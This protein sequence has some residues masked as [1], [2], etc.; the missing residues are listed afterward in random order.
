MGLVYPRLLSFALV[1]K[2][3]LGMP[4]SPKL[5]FVRLRAA[6]VKLRQHG[7]PK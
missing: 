5:C 4:I 6:E 1:P 2:F 3:H 7:I